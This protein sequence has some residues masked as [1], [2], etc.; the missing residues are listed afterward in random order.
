MKWAALAALF[1]AAIPIIGL[2]GAAAAAI[3]AGAI[4]ASFSLGVMIGAKGW[5]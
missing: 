3:V 2:P 1:I 5:R 4:V